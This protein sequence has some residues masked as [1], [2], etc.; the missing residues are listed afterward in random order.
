MNIII[1][2][3]DFWDDFT[4]EKYWAPT[5]NSNI[6]ELVNNA[7]YSNQYTLSEKI[8]GDWRMIIKDN[9]GHYYMRGRSESV[10][11]VFADKIDWVPHI[12][13]E[14]SFLPNGSVLLGEVYLKNN[15]GSRKVT[16]ILGCLKEKALARQESGEKLTYYIFDV[17]AWSGRSVM[18]NSLKERIE[19]LNREIASYIKTC[20][21]IELSHYIYDTD[22]MEDY[23]ASVLESGGEGVVLKRLDGK[24]EQGKRTARKSIKVKKEIAQTIDCYIT[25][26]YKT[27]RIEYTGKEIE[28]WPYWLNVRTGEKF[29][30]PK[31]YNE[32]LNG[33]GV[34][35]PITKG[36]FYN[37]AGAIELAVWR[38]GKETPICWISNITED[39]KRDI[40]ID[41][42]S[43][44]K[45]VVEVQ[46]MQIEEDT[47]HL[48]HAKI[49]GW[50]KDKLWSDCDGHEIFG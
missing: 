41:R 29:N 47:K 34:I 2:G 13:D 50:R 14:L 33:D 39:V 17:L 49:I 11:G 37:W 38:D 1:D 42:T 5:K 23:I 12:K 25:G 35:K 4:A 9:Y 20:N 40:V 26:R 6:K 21:Y 7:I 28:I 22:K 8:D 43:L 45:T 44:I 30:D 15:P 32:Y 36:Y 16:T 31:L 46:A 48:R 27:S 10:S 19:I 3:I 18:G 24:Y